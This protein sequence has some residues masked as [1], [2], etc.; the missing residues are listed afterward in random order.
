[1]TINTNYIVES[2][3]STVSAP[4]G[5]TQCTSNTT[6]V[7]CQKGRSPEKPDT[8]LQEKYN[9]IRLNL[10]KQTTKCSCIYKNFLHPNDKHPMEI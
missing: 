6:M 5:E 2:Y 1:M 9:L 3:P 7:K 4:K 8:S 10:C